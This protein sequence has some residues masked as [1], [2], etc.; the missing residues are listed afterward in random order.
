MVV[1]LTADPFDKNYSII[2]YYDSIHPPK[3]HNQRVYGN[4]LIIYRFSDKEF[5]V[6]DLTCPYRANEDHCSLTLKDRGTL[7]ECPCCKSVYLLD[8]DGFPST[9]S[10]SNKP[11]QYY[12]AFLTNNYTQLV[13]TNKN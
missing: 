6:W 13:I 12:N 1:S 8:S 4:G 9:G 10:K 2:N 7:P 5:L 11:L 3:Q